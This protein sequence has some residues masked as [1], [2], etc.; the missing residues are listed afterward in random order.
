M[1]EDFQVSYAWYAVNF[2][3]AQSHT[4]D[5]YLSIYLSIYLYTYLPRPENSPNSL[6]PSPS[7]GPPTRVQAPTIRNS[8]PSIFSIPPA[9]ILS[10]LW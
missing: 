7:L 8:S 1:T 4:Y 2:I 10:R 3:K 6:D 5:T 9:N